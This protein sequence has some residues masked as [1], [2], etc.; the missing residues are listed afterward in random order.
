LVERLI[1]FLEELL[2][3][4]LGFEKVVDRSISKLGFFELVSDCFEAIFEELLIILHLF[5]SFLVDLRIL[6]DRPIVHS[7]RID[8]IILKNIDQIAKTCYSVQLQ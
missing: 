1:V 4:D 8:F 7:K 2:I 3:L 6:I 5:H